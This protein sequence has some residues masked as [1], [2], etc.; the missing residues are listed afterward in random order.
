[1]I[2]YAAGV[3]DLF[4]VGHLRLLQRARRLCDILIV[5]VSTNELVQKVK[6]KMPVIPL[7]QRIEIIEGL[8]FVD[9]V[10]VQYEMDKIKA[11]DKYDF[12]VIFVGSDHKGEHEWNNYEYEG[13][14]VIYLPNT[15]G[16]S[17]TELV[18]RIRD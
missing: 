15:P 3:W 7:E 14:R 1:M 11:W 18:R 9:A 17:T 10:V 4:H 6:G 16:I 8:G 12:D 5:G 13:M 2:G